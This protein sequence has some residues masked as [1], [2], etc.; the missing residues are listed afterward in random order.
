MEYI[1]AQEL[2]RCGISAVDKVLEK[3]P[4]YVVKN[5]QPRYVALSTEAYNELLEDLAEARLAASEADLE[6]GWARRGTALDLLKDA[7]A[8]E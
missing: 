5:N 3:G 7:R 4:V 6:A 1:P 8:E 2:K